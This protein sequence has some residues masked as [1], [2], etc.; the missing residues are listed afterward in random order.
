MGVSGQHYTLAM[1]YPLVPIGLEAGL[2]PELVWMQRLEEEFFAS[3]GD[4]ILVVKSDTRLTE[5]PGLIGL[6]RY[7]QKFLL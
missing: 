1:L 2:A 5:L 3:A 4:Q 7:G 6:F